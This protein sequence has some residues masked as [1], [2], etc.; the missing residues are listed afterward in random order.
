[1]N[2][3][4]QNKEKISQKEFIELYNKS[5]YVGAQRLVKRTVQNSCYTEEEI[6]ELLK[7]GIET[8]KDVMHILAWK[9]GK[10]RHRDSDEK[11]EWV[12][13]KGCEN[14]EDG[15][16]TLRNG[17]IDF[18]SFAEYIVENIIDLKKQSIIQPQQVLNK[19]KNEAPSGIGTV[20]L[21]TI[22]YFLSNG[23]YP[24]YDRFAKIAID[25]IKGDFVP[26]EYIK[27][28]A[29]PAKDD[30]KFDYVM[31]E[32]LSFK[33]D[34]NAIFGDAYEK[35]RDVDRALW[36]YGHSFVSGSKNCDES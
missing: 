15:I 36:V 14:T 26:G 25:A 3:Y 6:D 1:M 18:N 34:I 9:V 4:D 16:M 12:F 2:L 31:D 5:Y 20:Y 35:N 7:K 24:I 19:L 27:Y 13:H 33:A 21:I 8:K 28:R 23:E 11:K 32:I 30:V 22:L 29:L 17:K 10:I